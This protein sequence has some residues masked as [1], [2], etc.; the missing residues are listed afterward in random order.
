MQQ[1]LF[2]LPASAPFMS[3]LPSLLSPPRL[4]LNPL[5]CSFS[6]G[7]PLSLKYLP[8][9]PSCKALGRFPK[10]VFQASASFFLSSSFLQRATDVAASR[11]THRPCC[12]LLGRSCC[13][14]LLFFFFFKGPFHRTAMQRSLCTAITPLLSISPPFIIF[15][16]SFPSQLSPLNHFLPP[17]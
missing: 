1:T 10:H 3:G 7:H 15:F 8:A 2:S 16:P 5:R 12:S 17:T 11:Q 14:V 6:P 4:G 9:S 13:S